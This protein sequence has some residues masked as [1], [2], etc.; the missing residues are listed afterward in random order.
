LYQTAT[1]PPGNAS[2]HSKSAFEVHGNK[3][4]AN[5]KKVIEEKFLPDLQKAFLESCGDDD[6]VGVTESRKKSMVAFIVEKTVNS[7]YGDQHNDYKQGTTG[8]QGKNHTANAFR[9]NLKSISRHGEVA[10]KKLLAKEEQK[11]GQG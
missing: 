5:A 6:H 8:R 3:C 9:T 7:Y 11:R 10:D 1:F 4:L 2:S